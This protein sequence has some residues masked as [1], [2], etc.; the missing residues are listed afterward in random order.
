MPGT[1]KEVAT[2]VETEAAKVEEVN[3]A[4]A[5]VSDKNIYIGLELKEKLD[6]Q[7]STTI[8]RSAL[9]RMIYLEPNYAIGVTSEMDLVNKIKD[10]A[11]GFSLGHPLSSFQNEIIE[12]DQGISVKREAVDSTP[13]TTGIK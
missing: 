11:Q 9:D 10:V 7:K 12:I 13:G 3:Q 6:K 4:T 1:P 8:E 5:L 2:R